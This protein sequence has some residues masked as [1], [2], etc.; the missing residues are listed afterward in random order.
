M[1]SYINIQSDLISDRIKAVDNYIK[2]KV[3]ILR[4]K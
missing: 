2:M 3:I 4:I 1:K